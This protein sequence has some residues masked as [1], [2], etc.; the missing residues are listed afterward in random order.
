MALKLFQPKTRTF[1]TMNLPDADLPTSE[2]LLLNILIELQ[3]LTQQLSD[4]E[5]NPRL[6]TPEDTRQSLVSET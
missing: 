2:I 5:G 1:V 3:V 6:E 4:A